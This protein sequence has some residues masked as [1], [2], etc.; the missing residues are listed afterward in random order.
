MN[1]DTDYA[2]LGLADHSPFAILSKPRI[3]PQHYKQPAKRGPKPSRHQQ[4]LS[5]LESPEE[6]AA[7][8]LVNNKMTRY[9]RESINTDTRSQADRTQAICRGRL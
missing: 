6:R 7:K 8:I 1:F 9:N 4:M 2:A 3:A 5:A